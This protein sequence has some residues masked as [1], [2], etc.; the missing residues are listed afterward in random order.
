[1][2]NANKQKNS[3]SG[4]NTSGLGRKIA[5]IAVAAVVVIA[6]AVFIGIRVYYGSH[7]YPD[8][9]IGDK[10]VSGMTL[11]ESVKA[12]EKVYGSYQLDIKGR[13]DGKLTINGDDIDYKVGVE[14]AVKKAFEQQHDKF[15]YSNL[16]KNN[17]TKI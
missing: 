15:S 13:K 7:W 11:S 9:K 1:M 8:T 6:A 16:F 4:N 2:K 3:I 10:D 12:M 5:L 17:D 14:D